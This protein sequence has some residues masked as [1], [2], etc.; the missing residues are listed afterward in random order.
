MGL[1][2]GYEAPA[3]PQTSSHHS[4]GRHHATPPPPLRQVPCEP[5]RPAPQACCNQGATPRCH[6]ESQESAAMSDFY[7]TTRACWAAAW[8]W[9]RRVMSARHRHPK[10][11]EPRPHAAIQT[12][13]VTARPPAEGTGS[14]CGSTLDRGTVVTE[15]ARTEL[16][17]ECRAQARDWRRAEH[18]DLWVANQQE[19]VRHPSR[20][21]TPP[22]LDG[23][24]VGCAATTGHLRL[25][26]KGRSRCPDPNNTLA[27][28]RRSSRCAWFRPDRRVALLR[29]K[30]IRGPLFQRRPA[31]LR[32]AARPCAQCRWLH[33]GVG[34]RARE[35]ARRQRAGPRRGQLMGGANTRQ[36]A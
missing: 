18:R 26:P 16:G 7:H 6:L 15:T 17:R 1:G 29:P 35:G 33:V 32:A 11:V 14:T 31:Q 9:R 22:R 25:P 20:G 24:S 36:R 28:F 3:L 8:P 30:A 27:V 13:V 23:E 34:C 19:G 5:L 10:P 2:S 4:R 21:A 12:H